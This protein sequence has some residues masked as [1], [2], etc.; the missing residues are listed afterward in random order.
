MV[1]LQVLVFFNTT[2]KVPELRPLIALASALSRLMNNYVGQEM[3]ALVSMYLVQIIYFFFTV[4][5]RHGTF[6]QILEQ[7]ELKI[8]KYP[9]HWLFHPQTEAKITFGV[10]H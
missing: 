8:K 7:K 4:R 9:L 1:Y 2:S 10:C 5:V 3:K 6:S